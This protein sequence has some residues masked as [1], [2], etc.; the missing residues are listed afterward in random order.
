MSEKES[1]SPEQGTDRQDALRRLLLDKRKHI[2]DIAQKEFA[3]YIKGDRQLIETVLDEGDLAEIDLSEGLKLKKLG[4]YHDTISKIDEALRKVKEN[5]YGSCEDCGEE[6]NPERL[7]VLP[8]A[9]RCRDCQETA[10]E[11]EAVERNEEGY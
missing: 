10:E 4:S 2:I 5:T 3:D 6:I 9:I 11:I 7:K 1:E 8:F